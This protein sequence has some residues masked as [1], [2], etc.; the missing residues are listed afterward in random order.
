[1]R[2]LH[3]IKHSCFQ[4][5]ESVTENG[6][7]ASDA[8]SVN[9]RN[10]VASGPGGHF[11]LVGRDSQINELRTD[12]LMKARVGDNNV[13]SVWGTP[14]VGKSDLVRSL[15]RSIKAT[16]SAF[17]NYAWVDVTHPFIA[18]DFFRSLH[19]ELD[20]DSVQAY[21]NPTEGCRKILKGHWSLIVIDNLQSIKE[22]DIIKAALSGFSRT[23]IVITTERSAAFHCASTPELVFNVKCL[24]NDSAINVFKKVRCSGHHSLCST[25]SM[26]L[27]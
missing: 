6:D 22:W 7:E 12:Y 1:M 5:S 10:S 19:L 2:R 23:I 15:Y 21:I 26:L 14:G 4:A 25:Y 24:D 27:H 16:G 20:N 11:T 17:K 9:E 18:T 8:T 13:I 3:Q